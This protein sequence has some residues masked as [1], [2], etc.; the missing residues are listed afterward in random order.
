MSLV[1][2]QDHALPVLAEPAT[3]CSQFDCA[4]LL[5]C[6]MEMEEV[7]LVVVDLVGGLPVTAQVV[8][9]LLVLDQVYQ[10]QELLEVVKVMPVIGQVRQ[11]QVAIV[12]LVATE[13]ELELSIEMGPCLLLT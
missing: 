10:R 7:H 8:G 12:F 5:S 2:L 13:L 9:G 4:L 1:A 3:M 6:A 11:M